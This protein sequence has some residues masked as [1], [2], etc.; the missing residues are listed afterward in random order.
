M[1]SHYLLLS[2]VQEDCGEDPGESCQ[3]SQGSWTPSLQGG[4]KGAGLVQP[5]KAKSKG[6]LIAYYIYLK[7]VT[8]TTE[9]AGPNKGQQGEAA[10]WKVCIRKYQ[11]KGCAA[12]EKV[13]R[14]VEDLHP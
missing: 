10:P 1:E 2:L 13:T 14:E 12:L 11:G 5:D 6:N 8:R 4:G 9:P 7:V 3:D